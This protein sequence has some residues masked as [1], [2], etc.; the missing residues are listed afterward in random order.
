MP[1]GQK[2]FCIFFERSGGFAGITNTV[3]LDSKTLPAEEAEK[4]E[5]MIISS[6]FFEDKDKD[7]PNSNRPDQFQYKITIEYE[8]KKQTR[9][10]GE[11]SVPESLRPL[12]HYLTLKAR[13]RQEK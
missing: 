1:A 4:L 12:V 6:G 11:S 10:F 2:P 7:M 8:G 3:E 9:E 5:E 13:K